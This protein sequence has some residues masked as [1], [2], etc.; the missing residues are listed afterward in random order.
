MDEKVN[1]I[2]PMRAGSQRVV[3][4]NI[5]PV[6]GRPLYEYVID[7]LLGAKHIDRIILSTDIKEI[8]ERYKDNEKFIILE[9]P[10]NLKGN[11]SMNWIIEDVLNKINWEHFMQMHV[12]TP[13]LTSETIDK[14]IEKYFQH[15]D[16][17]DSLFSVNEKQMRFFDKNWN[18]INHKL[19]DAPMTQ[20]LEI[21]YEENSLFYIF[22]RDSFHK[23]KHRIGEKPF[24]FKTPLIESLD[25]DTEEHFELAELLFKGKSVK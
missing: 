19:E 1:A 6:N 21:W 15:V 17:Y 10:E 23:K 18:P 11:T 22:S 24:L 14:A 9:R 2:L 12:T 13:L 16:N 5:R 8:L 3:N 25:L 7:S 20:D 4:K